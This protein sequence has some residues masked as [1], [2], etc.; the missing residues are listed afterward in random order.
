MASSE[1]NVKIR[2]SDWSICITWPKYSILIGQ[3]L[4]RLTI[5]TEGH[6]T[7]WFALESTL[8]WMGQIADGKE[9]SFKTTKEPRHG[10]HTAPM[11]ETRFDGWESQIL[12]KNLRK[13]PPLFRVGRLQKLFY[14][15]N[16]LVRAMSSNFSEIQT[17]SGKVYRVCQQILLSD[18]K[19]LFFEKF[20]KIR[21]QRNRS[22]VYNKVRIL[23]FEDG[24]NFSDFKFVRE[25]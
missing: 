21:Q 8:D 13:Y 5:T 9:R 23:C 14:L 12:W 25:R 2:P 15:P 17:D 3:V 6:H 10:Y 24:N 4:Y 16:K 20:G 22:V 18:C 7:W 19:L 1:W 11:W